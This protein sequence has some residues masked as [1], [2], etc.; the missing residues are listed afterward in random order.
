MNKHVPDDI[1]AALLEFWEE[2]YHEVIATGLM[3]EHE[4]IETAR[5]ALILAAEEFPPLSPFFHKLLKRV[6]SKL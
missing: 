6:R 2:Q 5:F 3:Q 1:K 4:E